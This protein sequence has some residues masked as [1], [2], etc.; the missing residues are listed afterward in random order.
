MLAIISIIAK[1]RYFTL[2]KKK[3]V[4]LILNPLIRCIIK[5]TSCCFNCEYTQMQS[6]KILNCLF[7]H[8]DVNYSFE[9]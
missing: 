4:T 6:K 7:V 1:N 3:L 8:F 5:A 9:I 2:F